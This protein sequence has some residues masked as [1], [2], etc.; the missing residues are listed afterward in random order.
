MHIDLT[1]DEYQTIM[2]ALQ[3]YGSRCL[4]AACSM[5][6]KTMR[7]SNGQPFTTDEV[8]LA[9]RCANRAFALQRKLHDTVEVRA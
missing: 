2:A 3:E 7:R 6:Q 5:A 1:D 8:S 9:Q 4:D